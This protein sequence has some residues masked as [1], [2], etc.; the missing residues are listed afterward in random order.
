M[1]KT[2]R[3]SKSDSGRHG[4][5][6]KAVKHDYVLQNTEHD[7]P[8]HEV[9]TFSEQKRLQYVK[10]LIA[11][12]RKLL[13]KDEVALK[14]RT[15]FKTEMKDLRKLFYSAADQYLY[16]EDGKARRW[17]LGKGSPGSTHVYWSRNHIW[18]MKTKKG[19]LEEELRSISPSLIKRISRFLDPQNEGMKGFRN[20]AKSAIENILKFLEYDKRSGCAFPPFHA[21]FFADRFL[22]KDKSGIVLDPCAGWG[23]RLI[24]SL[25]VNRKDKVT[26]VGIDPEERNRAAYEGL[27]R[28]ATI[29]LKKEIAAERESVIFYEPFE[30]WVCSS[31]A[32]HF[33]GSVDLVITSPPYFGAEIYNDDN[34]KQ[35][36]SRYD[37]YSLWRNRF[38]EPLI[39]GAYDLLKT[40][41]VFVLN[42][43]DVAEAPRLEKDA[44]DLAKRVGFERCGFFKLAMALSPTARHEGKIKQTLSVR[45]KRF[46]Y[47]PVFVFRK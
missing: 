33:I 5:T 13:K 35:S 27:T 24:G 14:R 19:A 22:P 4:V 6:A 34:T 45:G 41:G 12:L 25:L 9:L 23:G 7:L 40:G 15:S 37:D 8:L 31:Q 47:E 18:K 42:V 46:R 38:Y 10:S 44:N 43:A 20:E 11:A 17:V 28:R 1:A 39:Q 21:K 30:D 29:W 32:K 26:Y 3:K 36:T 16:V 2:S